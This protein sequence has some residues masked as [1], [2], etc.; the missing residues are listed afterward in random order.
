VT[1]IPGPHLLLQREPMQTAEV[2]ASFVSQLGIR[3]R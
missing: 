3:E 2:V 1:A